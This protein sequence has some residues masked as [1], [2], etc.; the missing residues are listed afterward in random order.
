MHSL[1]IVAKGLELEGQMECSGSVARLI[2][3]KGGLWKKR[4][5]KLIKRFN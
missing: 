4:I 1:A 3:Q 2:D 5:C